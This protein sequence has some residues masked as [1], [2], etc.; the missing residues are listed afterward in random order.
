M[1]QFVDLVPDERVA[2]DFGMGFGEGLFVPG[3][4]LAVD[5]AFGIVHFE[6]AENFSTGGIGGADFSAA[7]QDPIGLEK[8]DGFADV[9]RN[10]RIILRQPV[11]AVDLDGEQDGNA[12]LFEPTGE[13][14]D[15]GRAPTVAVEDDSSVLF[16]REGER[17]VFP[18]AQL[19][20]NEMVRFTDSGVFE[21]LSSNDGREVLIEPI[22]EQDFVAAEVVS[23]DDAANEANHDGFL[24]RCC[25]RRLWGKRRRKKGSGDH[26]DG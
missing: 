5:V 13:S 23:G 6:V 14:D 21:D 12:F 24:R 3:I 7:V 20:E 2:F 22:G 25:S 16:L 19:T 18:L 8:V 10:D 17:R 15:G 26:E 1:D 11:D 9:G 4:I